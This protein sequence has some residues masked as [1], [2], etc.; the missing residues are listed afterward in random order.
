LN[1]QGLQ[2]LLDISFDDSLWDEYGKMCLSCGNCNLVCPRCRCYDVQ[3]YINLG[4]TSGERVRTWSS[5][6]LKEHGLVTGG[7]NF[8]PTSKERIRNRFNCKGSLRE[9]MTNC[10]GCGR[11][12]VFCPAKIDFVEIMKKVRGEI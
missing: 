8:R 7:L 5:C 9:G 10:V 4:M 11:C 2:D 1:M 3:D 6:M 12:T